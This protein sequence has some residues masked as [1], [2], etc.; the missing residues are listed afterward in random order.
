MKS[1]CT[2][3]TVTATSHPTGAPSDREITTAATAATVTANHEARIRAHLAAALLT[4]MFPTATQAVFD[5][6]YEDTGYMHLALIYDRDTALLWHAEYISDHRDAITAAAI[7]RTGGHLR[8]TIDPDT[9][10][11]VEE[12]IYDVIS[13]SPRLL[14]R[15]HLQ[16]TRDGEPRDYDGEFYTLDLAAA[17]SPPTGD[18]N[19]NA[20]FHPATDP[21]QQPAL[22]VAGLRVS[23]HRE[24]DGSFTVTINSED[25]NEI[26]HADGCP[27]LRIVV[28]E[29]RVYDDT[30]HARTGRTSFT[31][32]VTDTKPEPEL[33]KILHELPPVGRTPRVW[34]QRSSSDGVWSFSNSIG[35][36]IPRLEWR[37]FG[38]YQHSIHSK[39]ALAS[40]SRVVHFRGSSTSSCRVPQKDSIMALS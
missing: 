4:S 19:Q 36:R 35:L 11:D 17:A 8:P 18:D 22:D 25:A 10:Q 6:S 37:R 20:V 33:Q 39:M 21:G 2:R 1:I 26:G 14:R 30:H 7:E 3:P 27:N 29:A 24:A 34:G 23:V 16:G 32:S 40:S 12:L 38:L 31:L 5:R 13:Q 28:N 15:L 9:Q